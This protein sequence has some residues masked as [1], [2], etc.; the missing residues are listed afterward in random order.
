[1][2]G[3]FFLMIRRPPRST[4]TDTLFP[5][6]T[7]FRSLGAA[8]IAG[9]AARCT[10]AQRRR[11]PVQGAGCSAGEPRVRIG[12]PFRALTDLLAVALQDALPP[13]LTAP[14]TLRPTPSTVPPTV[15][16]PP[17]DPPNEPPSPPTPEEPTSET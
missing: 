3:C 12:L 10:A 14:E 2:F 13:P 8:R 7:L 15:P 11:G 9:H 1:M 6:T 5:D 16:V 17:S 4:R